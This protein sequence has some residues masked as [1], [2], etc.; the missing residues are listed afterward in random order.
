ME[1][2]HSINWIDENTATRKTRE[3]DL[4]CTIIPKCDFIKDGQQIVGVGIFLQGT[5]DFDHHLVEDASILLR[6]MAGKFCGGGH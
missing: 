6:K 3:V 5:G 1:E 2:Y 4:K